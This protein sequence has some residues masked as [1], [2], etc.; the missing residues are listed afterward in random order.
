[1]LRGVGIANKLDDIADTRRVKGECHQRI[2]QL[3]ECKGS[4]GLDAVLLRKD[5]ETSV[6]EE[7]GGVVLLGR[8]I[9]ARGALVRELLLRLW[10]RI[11]FVVKGLP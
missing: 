6:A 9:R 4:Q 3:L 10:E 7:Y 1:M 11:D 5:V 8:T 2:M